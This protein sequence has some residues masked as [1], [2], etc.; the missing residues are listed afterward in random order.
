MAHPR[1]DKASRAAVLENGLYVTYALKSSWSL[2]QSSGNVQ[3]VIH[4]WSWRC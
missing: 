2:A 4:I 1:G 3:N